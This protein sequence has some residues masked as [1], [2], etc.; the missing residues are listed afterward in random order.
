MDVVKTKCLGKRLLEKIQF[1]LSK[2]LGNWLVP[3]RISKADYNKIISD[4]W[5]TLGNVI[6]GRRGNWSVNN[7]EWGRRFAEKA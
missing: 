2:S 3:R 6:V 7:K 4:A 1:S 5:S